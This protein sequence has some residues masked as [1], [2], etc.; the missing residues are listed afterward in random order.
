MRMRKKVRAGAGFIQTQA[1]FDIEDFKLWLDAIRGEGIAQ[2][3]AILAGVMPLLSAAEAKRLSETFT[4]FYIPAEVV[5]RLEAAGSE[6]A[7]RVEG[8]K[9]CAETIGKL[10]ALPG[11]RGI[12]MFSG[13]NESVVPELISM[14]L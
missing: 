3:T 4:D 6:D 2:K 9:I 8:L 10:R 14:A 7:Q 1:V 12:H 11:L 13:G 5:S